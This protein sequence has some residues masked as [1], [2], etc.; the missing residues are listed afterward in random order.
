MLTFS[1][2][3]R[4]IA[5]VD[6]GEYNG[7]ILK[8]YDKDL[9]KERKCCEKCTEKCKKGKKCCTNCKM[10]CGGCGSGKNE[11]MDIDVVDPMS[12]LNED[13]IRGKGKKST[14]KKTKLTT[15]QMMLII[16][17][18]IKKKE[19]EE[20]GLKDTY[21]KASK[22]LQNKLSTQINLISG[23][24]LPMPNDCLIQG[25]RG[26]ISG[27]A[28]S[29]KSRWCSMYIE[30]FIKMFPKFK[31]FLFSRLEKDPVLDKIKQIKRIMIN[32]ELIDNPI[33][34][35]ELKCS[36]V[37]FDDVDTGIE[38]KY[39]DVLS[40]LKDDLC[41]TGRHES[42][43]VLMT[44]H[45]ATD[46]KRTRKILSDVNFVVFFPRSGSVMGITYFL[47][48]YMGMASK[49]IKKI[50]LLPSRWIMINKTYPNYILS[51]NGCILTSAL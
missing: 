50:M 38:Q 15:K 46:Y 17:S 45:V 35:S 3:G 48:N 33:Q 28:G 25:E 21:E 13:E 49:Q 29:G 16:D 43:Y 27:A 42:I 19:P 31:I 40:K 5:K 11:K 36:L 30:N 23:S 9:E 51:E 4:P 26:Y 34:P 32:D 12:L 2:Q 24:F 10:N 39:I 20:G 37:L 8:I 47:K 6:G 44:S 41:Q 1:E 14:N 22:E 7:L 18:L